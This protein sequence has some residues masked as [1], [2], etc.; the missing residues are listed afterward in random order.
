MESHN[1][2]MKVTDIFLLIAMV[3]LLGQGKGDVVFTED[4]EKFDRK[5]WDDFGKTPSAVRIVDGG[6]GGGKCV[7]ITATLG[8]DTGAHLYKMLQPGLDTCFLRFYVKFEKQHDY[9]HHFVHL[10]GYSPATRW[11]Q[12]GAGERP[13]G[14]KRFSTGIEPWGNWGRHPPP[15]AW[16]FY[17]YWCEMKKSRDGKFWGN[18]FAPEKPVQ[19]ERDRWICVEIMLRCNSSPD[20]ADGEQALWIDGKK[21]GSWGGF[22]WRTDPKLEVNG[23]WMLYYITENAARQNRV[24]EPRKV[25][26]VQFDEIVVSKSYI[27]PIIPGGR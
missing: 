5:R 16:N 12:G 20:K 10:V 25:N 23:I 17:T 7:E 22:R 3:L 14:D 15:G 1:Q 13:E 21:M 19:V 8:E 9:I 27:G 18:S 2:A 6:L 11:P 26:K 24:K 4:F